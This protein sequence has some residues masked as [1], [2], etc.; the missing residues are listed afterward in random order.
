MDSFCIFT[1]FVIPALLLIIFGIIVAKPPKSKKQP[2]EPQTEPEHKP[3]PTL[4]IKI[5]FNNDN[6]KD[7]K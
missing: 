3:K 7:G 5:G 1:S 2:L 4:S 6:D